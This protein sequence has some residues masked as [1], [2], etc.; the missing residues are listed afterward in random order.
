MANDRYASEPVKKTLC[1]DL[2]LSESEDHSE[3]EPI[4]MREI[5]WNVPFYVPKWNPIKKFKAEKE[6]SPVSHALN[7]FQLNPLI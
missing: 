7:K 2:T 4:L 6:L 3:K 5:P 1:L